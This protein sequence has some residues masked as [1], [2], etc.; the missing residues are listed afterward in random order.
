MLEQ[1]ELRFRVTLTDDHRGNPELVPAL[2]LVARIVWIAIAQDRGVEALLAT[3]LDEDP[4]PRRD[5][6]APPQQRLPQQLDAHLLFFLDGDVPDGPVKQLLGQRQVVYG[7]ARAGSQPIPHAVG[8]V[9]RPGSALDD[10][11]IL[12]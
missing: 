6:T 10:E 5:G 2:D 8:D 7:A 1:V 4:G 12:E 9:A 3:Q 11:R